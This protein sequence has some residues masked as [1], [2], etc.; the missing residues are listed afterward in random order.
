MVDPVVKPGQLLTIRRTAPR[1][2]APH[3][4]DDDAGSASAAV[5][6]K[7]GGW[8]RMT[9]DDHGVTSCFH[10]LLPVLNWDMAWWLIELIAWWFFQCSKKNHSLLPWISPRNWWPQQHWWMLKNY[11]WLLICPN[12]ALPTG[13]NEQMCYPS[14]TATLRIKNQHDHH[15]Y[16]QYGIIHNYYQ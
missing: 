15:Y 10:W 2:W 9:A 8:P 4:P 7:V 16:H 3:A 11:W 5:E 6:P 14:W 12:I 13:M 1:S